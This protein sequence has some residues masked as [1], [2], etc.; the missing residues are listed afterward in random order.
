MTIYVKIESS[1]GELARIEIE[2]AGGNLYEGEYIVRFAVSRGK[3]WVG[4][5]NRSFGA[6][7]RTQYNVLALLM[8][9]LN[10]LD[11]KELE[12]ESDVDPSDLEREVRRA[13]PALSGKADGANRHHR[14]AFWRR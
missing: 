2:N 12:L 11:P 5:H 7:P 8:Q 10:T 4:L 1:D 3:E 13:L 9:A 14:S 6:F